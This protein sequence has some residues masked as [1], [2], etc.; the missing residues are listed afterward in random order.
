VQNKGGGHGELGFQLAKKLSSND[1]IDSIT[2]LQD[3]SCNM[4]SEPFQSY[5]SDLSDDVT[6]VFAKLDE[7]VD[8]KTMQKWLGG[9]DAQFEYIYDNYSKGPEGSSKALL[10]C[11]KNWGCCKL[12]T[13]VSSA[14]V[15]QPTDTTQ[16]PMGEDSTPIKE[17]SGQ[18]KMDNYVSVECN[19]PLVSFRPQYIYG[20]KSNKY[21]YIDWY[22]DRL[23]RSLPLPIPGPGTQ[24]VSLTNS[25]DVA[26]IFAASLD[27]EEAAV[28]QR[29]FNCGTDKL[30]TYDE[31]A[32]LCAEVAG[33]PKEEVKIAHYSG[34]DLGKGKFPF[35]LTDFYVAPDMAKEKLGY[36]GAM[37]DLKDD[38]KWYYEDYKTRGKKTI[39]F[40]KDRE[41]IVAS[42]SSEDANVYDQ[43][44]TTEQ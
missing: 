18:A 19:L 3:D 33:I 14:G 17:S 15:Y 7:S 5:A 31:V 43:Y 34:D 28:K 29:F 8:A 4:K 25:Q 40:T 9:D 20:E 35:R 6:V 2:I 23:T 22:F 44:I 26:S 27:N 21:D 42:K 38:L 1:K 41:I 39:D 24:K 11:V 36:Q 16:F 12:Y 13:Y 30:V 10:D 37:N 32:Y